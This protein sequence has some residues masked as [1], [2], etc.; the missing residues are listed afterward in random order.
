[1]AVRIPIISE[2]DSKG[3][4][5]AVK[6]FQSLEGAGAKASFA[7]RKAALPA[8]AA[9]AGLAAIATV[10]TKA[11]IADQAAQR[12]LARTLRVSTKATDD[13]VK[14]VEKSIAAME[15]ATGIS[16]EQL[17]PAFANLVRGT[18]DVEKAQEGLQLALDISAATGKDLTT[19]SDAL[20]NAYAGNMRGLQSLSPEMRTL[21]REGADAETAMALLATTFGGAMAE[22]AET[23]EGKMRRFSTAMDNAKENIGFALIPALEA[24]MPFLQKVAELAE[25]NTQAF[26]ITAGVIGGLSVGILVLNAAMKIYRATLIVATAAQALFN[27]VISANPIG[28][29]VIGIAA[30]IAA[31][32][33]L[34]KKFG[35]V[36]ASMKFLSDAFMAHIINP[37]LMIN[38]LI[39]KVIKALGRLSGI[40]GIVRGVGGF[41]GNI[42]GLADGGI[43][44]GPT[45]AMIGEAG[46][47]AVV[48]LDRMRGFGG[49]VTVNINGGLATG[50]EIGAAVV[51]AIR[52]FNTV[53]GPANIQVA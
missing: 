8:A 11:A 43:V 26:I 23:A 46:P 7:I 32:V 34:E 6:E 36:S 50:A 48:P 3:I 31:L 45:L 24:A 2:F 18:Q 41:I 14:A 47:E 17:R 5:K 1:M 42:P 4:D 15:R 13:Q 52:Q 29:I 44:T 30:L 25:E 35:F 33:I 12:E 40:T 51:Q 49:G 27:F 16:D 39:V 10:A 53:N 22:N 37:L 21:I 28:L 19:V 38:D 20:S 9:V